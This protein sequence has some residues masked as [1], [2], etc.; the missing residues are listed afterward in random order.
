MIVPKGGDSNDKHNAPAAN[1]AASSDTHM[2]KQKSEQISKQV[3]GMTIGPVEGSDSEN[4]LEKAFIALQL[5]KGAAKSSVTQDQPEKDSAETETPERPASKT[6]NT[7]YDNKE[8]DKRNHYDPIQMFGFFVPTTLRQAQ[9]SFVEAVVKS[10]LA[11]V[12]LDSEMALL[13]IEIRRTRKT[14]AK[15]N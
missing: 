13:E 12:E 1:V 9:A 11:L 8:T 10:V 6:F 4:E 7:K 3:G 15:G 5:S 2:Q 14:I